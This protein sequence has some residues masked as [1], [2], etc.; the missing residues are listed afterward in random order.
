MK[1]LLLIIILVLS[2][3]VVG[4][5]ADEASPS[6]VQYFKDGYRAQSEDGFWYT[7]S[8]HNYVYACEGRYMVKER[9]AKTAPCMNPVIQRYIDRVLH[10][11]HTVYWH[12]INE[13]KKLQ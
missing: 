4:T 5:Y 11:N 10:R 8:T 3:G 13:L 12:I 2:L 9:R 6:E 7:S 1:K